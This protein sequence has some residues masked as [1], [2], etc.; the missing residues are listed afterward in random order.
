MQLVDGGKNLELYDGDM[1]IEKAKIRMDVLPDDG[2]GIYSGSD[3]GTYSVYA[4]G[5]ELI[6]KP[7]AYNSNGFPSGDWEVLLDETEDNAVYKGISKTIQQ[8]EIIEL[9]TVNAGEAV[10][11]A[12]LSGDGVMVELIIDGKT[13]KSIPLIESEQRLNYTWNSNGVQSVA[14]RFTGN[15]KVTL[16]A[17]SIGNSVNVNNV[18]AIFKPVYT[19]TINQ[20]EQ[21]LTDKGHFA[22]AYDSDGEMITD[23]NPKQ[24]GIQLFEGEQVT[25]SFKDY[26]GGY[27]FNGFT[28]TY[29]DG[30]TQTLKNNA[31]ITINQ[32]MTVTYSITSQPY[33]IVDIPDS[34][35]MEDGGT[36]ASITVSELNNM[37]SGDSLNVTISG[38]TDDGNVMLTDV[39]SSNTLSVAVTGENNQKL[40][41]NALVAKF[42]ENNTTQ[43][44]GGTVYFG[45]PTGNKIAGNY[46]GNITFNIAYQTA[47]N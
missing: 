29:D 11:D 6:L 37:Q 15:G 34:L 13:V 10:A 16:K 18:T 12:I 14:L 41:N 22:Y 8:P 1:V 24:N 31:R 46:T 20:E 19:L 7:T 35:E 25:L 2:Y 4:D 39:P 44:Q 23:A 26:D 33:Y 28:L 42:T 47:T 36:S 32:N 40:T 9:G 45:T 5:T 27:L 30:T 43:T 17:S 21:G 38:L 3:S